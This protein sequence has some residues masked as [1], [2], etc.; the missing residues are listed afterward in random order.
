MN[1]IQGKIQTGRGEAAY[2]TELDWVKH[3][4]LDKLGFTPYPGTLNVKIAQ[5]DVQ[6]VK[7]VE[8]SV[9]TELVPPDPQFCSACII[10]CTIEGILAA[11]V[12]PAEEVRIHGSDILELIAPVQIRDSLSRGEGDTIHISLANAKKD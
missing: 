9:K 1:Q 2:F 4:C 10:P 7:V 12:I 11:I 3:Q 6:Q 5:N 8:H